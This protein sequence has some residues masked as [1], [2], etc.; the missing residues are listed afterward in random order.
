MTESPE[1]TQPDA[2][3]I[4]G[5]PIDSVRVS[6]CLYGDDLDP[7]KVTTLLGCRPTTAG[8]KGEPLISLGKVCKV[9]SVQQREQPI[10]KPR[11]SRIG[12]WILSSERSAT[13]A[14]EQIQALL[15]RV[16]DDPA[17]WEQLSGYRIKIDCSLTL[18][19]WNRGLELS[20]ALIQQL[21]E[22][23]LGLSFDIYCDC[24]DE[25]IMAEGDPAV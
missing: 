12:V 17:A 20:S 10:R 13:D 6:L 11:I 7:D 22:R 19:A 16:T 1:E 24:E 14:E 3:V 9:P 4:I 18:R 25:E 23:R 2:T 8:R 15:Q 21:A 5:G